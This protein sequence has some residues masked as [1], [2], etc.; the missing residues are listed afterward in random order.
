VLRFA[1]EVRAAAAE[2]LAGG[3]GGGAAAGAAPAGRP[4]GGATA[5]PP[6]GE[7]APPCV[8]FLP[9]ALTALARPRHATWYTAAHAT[10]CCGSF[11]AEWQGAAPALRLQLRGEMWCRP[12]RCVLS[13]CRLQACMKVRALCGARPARIRGRR[14]AV[15]PGP[16][17]G[18]I[19]VA[20]HA[21]ERARVPARVCGR[22]GRARRVRGGPAQGHRV[23]AGAQGPVRL[24]GAG[25]R[26]SQSLSMCTASYV[27]GL[28]I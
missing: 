27:R 11:C 28:L 3:A 17:G 7:E 23:P 2:Q 9:G 20:G 15:G 24:L 6:P 1:A 19:R 26:Q 14:G 5:A 18:R 4:A 21:A 12:K 13:S 25:V 10:S 16:G 8:Y 22:H